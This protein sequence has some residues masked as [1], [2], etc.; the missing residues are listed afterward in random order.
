MTYFFNYEIK[1]NRKKIASSSF[2]SPR[3]MTLDSQKTREPLTHTVID[4]KVYNDLFL[5]LKL[6]KFLRKIKIV[7]GEIDP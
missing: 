6:R 7:F 3:K 5:N 2:S 1:Y 4:V